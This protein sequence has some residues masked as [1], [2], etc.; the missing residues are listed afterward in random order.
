MKSQQLAYFRQRLEERRAELNRAI[1]EAQR[2]AQDAIEGVDE[3]GDAAVQ[4]ELA[5]TALDVGTR[6]TKE[7]E[8]IDEALRR[9]ETGEYGRCEVDGE[10]I[11]IGRLEVLPTARTCAA[12]ARSAER[13]RPPTL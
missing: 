10:E 9:I 7:Y 3:G 8:E 4:G 2:D 1:G 6:R 13:S 5:D 12:H 11:E